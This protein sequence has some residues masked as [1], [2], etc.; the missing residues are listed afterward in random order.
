M[1]PR[2]DERGNVEFCGGR[3]RSCKLQWGRARMSAEIR[4]ARANCWPCYRL[5]WGRARMSAEIERASVANGRAHGLQWGRARMSAEIGIASAGRSGCAEAS[6]GPRSDE[7]GNENLYLH[8]VRL[9]GW[10]QW[11]RARMSA[12]MSSSQRM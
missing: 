8:A 4:L 12:E 7:R 1:G 10:L 6:M 9:F 5:Q 2:S 3:W 11:G